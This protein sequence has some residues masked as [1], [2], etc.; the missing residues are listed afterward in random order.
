MPTNFTQKTV[1][2]RNNVGRNH[3]EASCTNEGTLLLAVNLEAEV[4]RSLGESHAPC[5]KGK[6]ALNPFQRRGQTV[7]EK[8]SN[9]Y[10]T[11]G[12]CRAA[13]QVTLQSLSETH[14]AQPRLR[15]VSDCLS[16][17]SWWFPQLRARHLHRAN[18]RVIIL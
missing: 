2:T 5:L 16:A 13:L 10:F 14:R 4:F 9:E 17:A 18:H 15:N 8:K 12:E 11:G 3:K 1:L 7:T 6:S